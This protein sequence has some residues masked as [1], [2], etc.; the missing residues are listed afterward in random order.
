MLLHPYTPKKIVYLGQKD[1]Y[2]N[3]RHE[4]NILITIHEVLELGASFEE[5]KE[6]N[7]M[8]NRKNIAS[9]VKFGL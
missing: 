7:K 1:F 6:I 3:G 9:P 8:R 4:K 2:E 5:R